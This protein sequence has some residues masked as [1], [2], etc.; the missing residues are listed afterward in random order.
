[1]KAKTASFTLYTSVVFNLSCTT[2]H[3]SSNP[4]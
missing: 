2:T 3:Y 4:L 1:M